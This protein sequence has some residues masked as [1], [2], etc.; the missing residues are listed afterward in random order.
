MVDV[1]IQNM[2]MYGVN[3]DE[4]DESLP[5][6]V[7]QRDVFNEVFL[8]YSKEVRPSS[9]HVGIKNVKS[10]VCYDD[11]K[12]YQVP[13]KKRGRFNPI[14]DGMG[15]KKALPTNFSPVTS[16]NVGISPQNLLTFNFNPFD[17]LV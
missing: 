4:A 14:Q 10:D 15:G 8:K 13:S 1:V 17:R 6:P 2:W 11:T 9:S 12:H 3:K 7:F 16:T 5:L